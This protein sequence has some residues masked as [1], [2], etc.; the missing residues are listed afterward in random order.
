MKKNLTATLLV[1]STCLSLPAQST[2]E[3]YFIGLG[4]R[5]GTGQETHNTGQIW[6]LDADDPTQKTFIHK[7]DIAVNGLA[8][9]AGNHKLYFKDNSSN[10]YSY[11]PQTGVK[12]FVTPLLE[13][14]NSAGFYNG[15]YYYI[16]GGTSKLYRYDV[17]TKTQQ[18]VAN[19]GGISKT[20]AQVSH[21]DLTFTNDR[22]TVVGN[23]KDEGFRMLHYELADVDSP[24]HPMASSP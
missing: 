15:G 5:Q 19:L 20:Y 8:W 2:L 22:L 4:T 1:S 12:E 11:D 23:V 14:T 24:P 6:L 21:G 16:A 7:H 17:S 13:S 18:T 3:G 10:L 9:D